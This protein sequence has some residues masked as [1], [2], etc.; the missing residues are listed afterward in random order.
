MG[1]RTR[2]I[3][4]TFGK[5]RIGIVKKEEI[6]MRTSIGRLT[7]G[8]SMLKIKKC[9]P[10]FCKI[11]KKTIDKGYIN[12]VYAHMPFSELW[13]CKICSEGRNDRNELIKHCMS[14]HG[15]KIPPIDVRYNYW[16]D[17]KVIK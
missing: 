5:R 17:I 7:S 9:I 10:L 12:H 2:T 6:K 8:F 14:I 3:R 11:C 16:K 13:R 15:E 1:N 4:K